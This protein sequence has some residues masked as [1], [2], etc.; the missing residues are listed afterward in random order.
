MI[1]LLKKI[2]VFKRKLAKVRLERY[3]AEH[4]GGQ[5]IN[6]VAKHVLYQFM[7]ANWARL[8]VYPQ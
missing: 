5:D 8:C 7:E 2:N 6:K 4:M 1:L 3:F